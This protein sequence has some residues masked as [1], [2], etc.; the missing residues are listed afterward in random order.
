MDKAWVQLKQY[1][2]DFVE[3]RRN[4]LQT[5]SPEAFPGITDIKSA[6]IFSRIVKSSDENG[7]YMFAPIEVVKSI[8]S[9]EFMFQFNEI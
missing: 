1:M 9:S 4:E 6:N 8:N 2:D 7:K 3:E 5:E